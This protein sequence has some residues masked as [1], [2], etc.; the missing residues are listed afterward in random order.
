MND[1][2][3]QSLLD[4]DATINAQP[5]IDDATLFEKF[6]EF[7]NDTNLLQSAVDYSETLRSGKYG[8]NMQ[9][10]NSKF[11]EFFGNA[12]NEIVLQPDEEQPQGNEVPL[13]A[14]QKQKKGFWTTP[15]GDILENVGGGVLNTLGGLGKLD[16]KVAETVV[17]KILFPQNIVKDAIRKSSL[18]KNQITAD[19]VLDAGQN[20]I[21][22]G[23]RY[24]LIEDEETGE[25][26]KKQYG[27]HWKEGNYLAAAGEIMLTAA[28]SAPTSLLAMVPGAGLALVSASA[29][30]QKYNELDT[31][32]DTEEMPEW[33]KWLN[34]TVSGSLEGATEKLGAKVDTKM[35]EPFMKKMTETTVKQILAKGGVNALIQTVTEG[36][37]ETLSQL[38]ENVVDYAT[39]VTDTYNPFEGVKDA[40]V[41]GAGGGAQFGGVTF[42][43]SGYRAAQLKAQQKNGAKAAEQIETKTIDHIVNPVLNEN[44]NV[45]DSAFPAGSK[46]DLL[47]TKELM[48]NSLQDH[49]FGF[50]HNVADMSEE[51][52]KKVLVEVMDDE[53]LNDEQKNAIV[54]F[55]RAANVER[56]MQQ[57]QETA[58]EE[59]N[60]NAFIEVRENTNHDTGTIVYAKFDNEEQPV[61]VVKG[62]AITED[63]QV[64][65]ENS[66]DIVY[67]KDA[68]GSTKTTT[69][70]N[71]VGIESMSVDDATAMSQQSVIDQHEAQRAE[72]DATVWGW[73]NENA[74]P[75]EVIADSE[76][77]A[78]IDGEVI[79]DPNSVEVDATEPNQQLEL[80][81]EQ[82]IEQEREQFF[83]SLPTHESG[84]RAGQIDQ[85]QMTPTQNIQYFEYQFGEERALSASQQQVE[86]IKK[87]LESE[88]KKLEN[89]PMNI[90]LNESVSAIEEQLNEYSGYVNSKLQA[91]TDAYAEES[92]QRE[93]QNTINAEQKAEQK[94]IDE[95]NA[96]Q[97]QLDDEAVRGVPDMSVDKA[98]DARNRGFRVQNG[99]KIDRQPVI[100]VEKYKDAER[101]FSTKEQDAVPVK[102]TIVDARQLQPSHKNGTRNAQYFIPETQPKERTDKASIEA[103]D[104]IASNINPTEITGGVTA[105]TGAPMANQH[106]EIIQGNGR[107]NA[108][109]TMY[110]GHPEQAQK[111]KQHLADTA[112]EYGMTA[113]E[114]MAMEQ[115]TAIDIATVEDGEAIRLGQLN[116]A[117]TESGGKQ[118][119]PAQQTAVGLGEKIGNFAGNLFHSTNDDISI[120]EVIDSTGKRALDYLHQLGLINNTQYESSFDERGNITPEAKKDLQDITAFVL[121]NGANDNVKQM[122]AELPDKSRK[123][124]LQ[125]I[126]RDVESNKDSR[127]V[128]EIQQAIEA[129]NILMQ[130]P[131]FASNTKYA[132]LRIIAEQAKNQTQMFNS[133]TELPLQKYSNFAI[134]LAI[135]FKSDSQK[136]LRQRFNSLY[137][138]VQGKGGDMFAEA[139]EMPLEEA[140]KRNFNNIDYV[141]NR[142]QIQRTDVGADNQRSTE[143]E[144][145][146]DRDT[147]SR[148]SDQA[149]EQSADSG[150]GIADDARATESERTE[151][152]TES[153]LDPQIE[154]YT[155]EV[156]RLSKQFN[157]PIK[158]HTS[159]ETIGNQT[160]LN[161][162]NAKESK[163]KGWYDV[164]TG[165]AHIYLPHASS[166]EDIQETFLHEALGHKGVRDFLGTEKHNQL[167]NNIFDKLP[168]E[169]QD[170]LL[171]EYGS[172]E[173]AADEFIS[174]VAERGEFMGMT[175]PTLLE[176]IVEAIKT[177]FVGADALSTKAAERL[178]NEVLAET[179]RG[180]QA[181]ESVNSGSI[182]DV[183]NN[184][185][186][187]NENNDAK[188]LFRKLEDTEAV[189][190]NLV[191]LHNIRDNKLKSALNIGGLAM[192]SIA[193][194]K[195][196][197]AFTGYGEITLIGNRELIDPK[198]RGTSVYSADAYTPTYPNISYIVK[199]KAVRSA[200]AHLLPPTMESAGISSISQEIESNGVTYL[201]SNQYPAI[202]FATHKGQDVVI[203]ASSKVIPEAIEY[204]KELREQGLTDFFDIRNN[205]EVKAK[206]TELWSKD[207]AENK[208]VYI[209]RFVKEDGFLNENLMRDYYSE[210]RDAAL[211]PD[212]IDD[213]KTRDAARKYIEENNLDKEY[214]DW[215]ESEYDKLGVEEK[216]FKG[217]TNAGNRSYSAHTL[218]NVVREM[219][220]EAKTANSAFGGVGVAKAAQAKKFKSV[221]Q[222][223]DSESKIVD[224]DT[225]QAIKEEVQTSLVD[226][227]E[228]LAPFYKY[229]NIFDA[230]VEVELGDLA[231]RGQ[232]E[233]F[234][235]IS[236]EV[237]SEVKELVEKLTNMPTQYFEAK[238]ERGVDI[239][240]FSGAMVPNNLSE[241][242]KQALK[243]KG[244]EVVEYQFDSNEDRIEKTRQATED[245]GVRFRQEAWHGGP[246]EITDG[247]STDKIGSG[248]GN[249]SFGWGLYFTDVKDIAQHYANKLSSRYAKELYD[250]G[251]ELPSKT[252]EALQDV[253]YLGFDNEWQ[254]ISAFYRSS[255]NNTL[256]RYDITSEQ[257]DAINNSLLEGKRHLY[258]VTLHDGKTAEQYDW[259]DW[260]ETVPE[261]QLKGIKEQAKEEDIKDRWGV[262]VNDEGTYPNSIPFSDNIKG[263]ELY[264]QLQKEFAMSPQD[265]SL[266]MLRAGIDGIRYPAESIARA[267][268]EA[269]GSN[270]VV[271]DEN[272]VKIEEHIRFR[273]TDTPLFRIIGEIGA[274]RAVGAEMIMKDLYVAREME[275]ANKTPKQVRLATG[276]ERGADGKWRYELGDIKL[277]PDFN[278]TEKGMYIATQKER[279]KELTNL[280]KPIKDKADIIKEKFQSNYYKDKSYKDSEEGKAK[281]SE[282]NTLAKEYKVY[283]K[284]ISDIQDIILDYNN[285]ELKS[286]N[287]TYIT[288]EELAKGNA[289][290]LVDI[291]EE[292]SEVFK[293]Y[294]S[295]KKIKVQTISSAKEQNIQSTID[296]ANAMYNELGIE[297]PSGEVLIENYLLINDK[298]LTDKAKIKELESVLNHEIQHAIQSIENFDNGGNLATVNVSDYKTKLIDNIKEDIDKLESRLPKTTEKWID[299]I[300]NPISNQIEE[301]RNKALDIKN[302]DLTYDAY[303][304]ISGEVE[305]R[306]AQTRMGM[307]EQQRRETLL[308]ETEDVAREEQIVIEDALRFRETESSVDVAAGEVDTNPTEEQKIA[309]NYKKGHVAVSGMNISIENPAGSVRSGIDQDGKAWE[310]TMNDHY[311]YFKNTK[312]K[313]GDH[314]DTFIKQGTNEDWAGTVYVVDQ[315]DTT[316]KEFDES[317]VML[318][319]ETMEEAKQ[320][321]MA[322]YEDGWDGFM[323]I[324]PVEVEAFK[325]WLYDGA[326]QGKAYSEYKAVKE[327]PMPQYEGETIAE[328]AQKV[329]EH[330]E[331]KRDQY[332]NALNKIT[333]LET[334][335]DRAETM[336]QKTM[337]V[338]EIVD[339]IE[340]LLKPKATSV[341]VNNTEEFR[342]SLEA[343]GYDKASLDT[344]LTPETMG[345]SS[346]NKIWINAEAMTAS[347]DVLDTWIHETYHQHHDPQSEKMLSLS[348]KISEDVFRDI[349]PFSY[350][351]KSVDKKIEEVIAFTSESMFRGLELANH[352]IMESIKPIVEE[353]LN[354]ITDGKFSKNRTNIHD[355]QRPGEDL[356]QN[357]KGSQRIRKSDIDGGV[358]TDKRG[359]NER[360]NSRGN[361]EVSDEV[362]TDQEL[363]AIKEKAQQDGTF[364][365]APNGEPTNLNE[366]QWLQT[367]TETFKQWFGDWQNNP[368]EASKVVDANGEPM[369][370]Y[371]G[372]PYDFNEFKKTIEDKNVSRGSNGYGFFFSPDTEVAKRFGENEIPVFL[373]IR[374]YKEIDKG[375][376]L[377]VK[378]E[379]IGADALLRQED[380]REDRANNYDGYYLPNISLA[381]NYPLSK[382]KYTKTVNVPQYVAFEANQ[383]KSATDNVGDFDSANNDIRFRETNQEDTPTRPVYKGETVAEYATKMAQYNDE[384]KFK[385]VPPALP[386]P[387]VLTAAMSF[388]EVATAIALFKG[389][390][391]QVFKDVNKEMSKVSKLYTEFVDR[392]APLEKILNLM[393]E[394]G[395]TLNDATNAYIDYMTSASKATRITQLYNKTRIEPLQE[396]LR[397][398]VESEVLNQLPKHNWNVVDEQTGEVINNKAITAYDQISLYLQ[399]RDIDEA[400]RMDDVADR[401]E[402]GFENNVHDENGKGVKASEYIDMFEKAVGKETVDK[403]W[404]NVR[405]V[406]QF[407]LDLQLEYGLITQEVYDEYTNGREYYV[408]QRGWRERDLNDRDYHYINDV[409]GTPDNPFNSAL[410]KAKGRTTLAGDPLAYMQSIGESSISSA[411]KNRTKQVFLEYAE[412][413]SDFARTHDWFGFKKVY[414]MAT[415]ARDA[416]GNMTY[417]RTYE[418]PTEIQLEQDKAVYEKL[419]DNR[420]AM[421]ASYKALNEKRKSAKQ[422]ETAMKKLRETEKQLQN[423]I[424]IKHTDS[425][426]SR[427]HQVTAKER[428]QHSVI[429]LKEGKEYEMIFSKNYD[430]ERVAN[431]LNRNFGGTHNT[432]LDLMGMVKQGASKLTRTMSALMTQ[433]N[434]DFAVKNAVRDYGTALISNISEFGF[435]YVL[436][437]QKNLFSPKTQSVVW[438]YV[439]SDQF[440]KGEFF[441]DNYHGQMLKDFFEDG[442]ATGWSFLKDIDQ[443]RVDMKRAIDPTF[444]DEVV[445]GQ[446]GVGNAFGLKQVFGML[447]EVSELNTRFAQ[448]LTSREAKNEDGTP[449]F[450]R[451]ES[452]TH[453]KEVTVNF[454]RRGNNRFFSSLFS[455]FNAQIQGT[456]KMFRMVRNPK[457]RK[458]LITTFS[459]MMVG[460]ILQALLQPD[461]DDEDDRQFTEW[462]QMT[463]LCIGKV[464]IPLPQG[465]RSFWGVG[466]Q[467]GMAAKKQKGIDESLIDGVNFFF[468]E[469]IPEQFTFWMNGFEIDERTGN[470]TYD[471]KQSV[472]GAMPTSLQPAFDVAANT[473][474][475]GGTSYRTEF[476][477]SLQDTESERTLGKH[478]VS[479]GA[480]WISDQLFKMGGGD[481]K[482]G[483]RLKKDQVSVVQGMWDINPSALETLFS[484][485]G[486]G[487]GKFVVDMI[488]LG[489]QIMDPEKDVD[490]SGMQIFNSFYK[491]PREYSPLDNEIRILQKKTNFYKNQYSR[492]KNDNPE[493][494]KD[495]TKFYTGENGKMKRRNPDAWER[496]L[497]EEGTAGNKMFDLMRESE[498]L[499]KQL[500]IGNVDKRQI[501]D[502]VE[503]M[504]KRYEELQ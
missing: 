187:Q 253:D 114:V 273:E 502:Q 268:Q 367:R 282:F 445:H 369:V 475:M 459:A 249:Q 355:R 32:P 2:F 136:E 176:K 186:K 95:Q 194:T 34:A 407:A 170:E 257:Y 364:M 325:E 343:H 74:D 416:D 323:A 261:S 146:R 107:T 420:D 293:E 109:Q 41:Y 271:F 396:V 421:E 44:V 80:T 99:V 312:G 17:G 467:I 180:L 169:K 385:V 90:E 287:S 39:G 143:R 342:N 189:K 345:L 217:Y 277:R 419:K 132:D 191:A 37:E 414:Y 394:K 501:A 68:D 334:A 267:G 387:P 193:I 338:Q 171:L 30:G 275:K 358:N 409:T 65:V 280:L 200:F 88:T 72:I 78:E 33:K 298:Y 108:L 349:L 410:I 85:S 399:A 353:Y 120:S 284:E 94:A 123:S 365:K 313:D 499:L 418:A 357:N 384:V 213:Y 266:F 225:H 450:T 8:D 405:A 212:R 237:R 106:G 308:S 464:K 438:Q 87:R 134:E 492:M 471:T 447:T 291:I 372:T 259:I 181:N 231:K 360:D 177:L 82:Q 156:D 55:V 118:R 460:G 163:V 77:V 290:R 89:D 426:A 7:A 60:T 184:V 487:T 223:K 147:G 56:Q 66:S 161:R 335:F 199:P 172:R 482:D 183:A 173:L 138:N 269:R 274:S 49:E 388:E 51:D 480:Q 70:D 197:M 441:A 57:M 158:V 86:V 251:Q 310:Q 165:E 254:T 129:Y 216:I 427:I 439:A 201:S 339:Q 344:F 139:V 75:G 246:H 429:V 128:G 91:K 202:A 465:F 457:V 500:E 140:V 425:E 333:E 96:I 15:I 481:I 243:Q 10:L 210:A 97:A 322:N 295:L 122:F 11:P 484:G 245:L 73:M 224:Y 159:T 363:Q 361:K 428:G 113:D 330:N 315:V 302:N 149:T 301:L 207:K 22:K 155:N 130:H 371:H 326:K 219:K 188:T 404:Q 244:L 444:M 20:M 209:D 440:G 472:R 46:L 359:E 455:F 192:P 346:G 401:G 175:K 35:I 263:S 260:Y 276:W 370:V 240:E 79:E 52:Q 26:R 93:A 81:P 61:V 314:I 164:N 67:Y 236:D 493:G 174:E 179:A 182:V 454:D 366:K 92:K 45:R 486:G 115:P 362:V 103:K 256:K 435:D 111:Y 321:Y 434:P 76:N 4:F 368:D 24:G 59:D 233:S 400:S 375:R 264:Q 491:Q 279:I 319:Y 31:N 235:D 27:D 278:M 347:S 40:F 214:K 317:K 294:P 203:K 489:N 413:N 215:I 476:T 336:V 16:E 382:K 58:F 497:D 392:A 292:S 142:E 21:E 452:A 383:I 160:A 162:I 340:I 288:S 248:E 468:G 456:N 255:R 377:S 327:A 285:P 324:T 13:N 133:E 329:S 23:T 238:I 205:S 305:A 6:P 488:T 442:S 389:S 14:A 102:R 53:T 307:T 283:S 234:N 479:A 1:K 150:D 100:A 42:S 356:Q 496:K 196:D 437:T 272:A 153:G 408:P 144:Q 494:Y 422:H 105:Y 119:I 265:A 218:E 443:L 127:I 478:N 296:V 270:Y 116:A 297:M 185:S 12:S 406:N 433:Y 18:G 461:P 378:P 135:V 228:S 411:L 376:K 220:R 402:Q 390:T 247:F 124:I 453:A 386:K 25:I 242:V 83:S 152:T 318:G 332:K 473:N 352:D 229:S 98:T 168:Q 504:N 483:S 432:D 250:D 71:I 137:D 299:E 69:A 166:I 431:V 474:F 373:N 337:V 226:I 303:R 101:K 125:T 503:W 286:K 430:G 112:H 38:G 50:D 117:D 380:W 495:L 19:D 374:N 5:D 436:E 458:G 348:S 309:G 206:L 395:A 84:K 221:E 141:S 469:L 227:R 154:E 397:K 54:N 145:E 121:F 222:M 48:D 316:T 239:S 300:H 110:E 470:L 211:N 462:E 477:N 451:Q 393:S 148:E 151:P 341:V 485:Y 423:L 28:S 448:Y 9:E 62:L 415:G 252:M 36:I 417:E 328:Y 29:A 490:V 43:M 281:M 391:D 379:F 331:N 466:T 47:K 230:Q 381:N 304:A 232:S 306:N 403:I 167:L 204:A 498:M 449:K 126:H 178:A 3:Q 398:I 262:S 241:D 208:K 354:N 131:E 320:A 258:K 351:N 463:N 350:W 311:G 63:G 157:T 64:D 190:N 198:N 104:R 446:F 412:E 424:Q 289:L 195:S